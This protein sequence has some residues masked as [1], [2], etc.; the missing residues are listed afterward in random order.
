MNKKNLGFAKGNNIGIKQARGKYIMLL[1][2]DTIVKE[3]A[4]EKLIEY[5][6]SVENEVEIAVS[7]LLLLPNDK[8]QTEYYMRF[9]NLWQ[10]FLYHNPVLRSVVMKIPFLSSLIAQNSGFSPFDVDQLPGA[11]LMANREIWKKVGLLDEKYHFLFED[12]DWCWRARKA[13]IKLKV[14]PDAKITHFGGASWRNKLKDDKL[15][16]YYQ[17]FSAMLLF[18]RKNYN[19]FSV[20]IFKW[21]IIINFFLTLK[22]LLAWKFFRSNGQQRSYLLQ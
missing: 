18:V 20:E 5:I 22:P 13:G 2:S 16:F 6:E 15:G 9:P 1:N 12:V 11:A 17:F 7:P 10:V 14:V 4:I 19:G 8:S 21:A 3:G